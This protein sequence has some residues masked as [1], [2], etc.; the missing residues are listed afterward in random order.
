MGGDKRAL[1]VA[2]KIRVACP[3]LV[4]CGLVCLKAVLAVVRLIVC[5][6]VR[7]VTVGVPEVV[8][9]TVAFSDE[10]D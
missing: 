10:E 5:E 8:L 6:A 7:N 1:L 2:L 9:L 4:W 3:H